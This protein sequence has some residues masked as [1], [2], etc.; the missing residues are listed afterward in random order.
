MKIPR[1][2]GTLRMQLIPRDGGVE[3]C[4]EAWWNIRAKQATQNIKRFAHAKQ[5]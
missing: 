3:V 2:C 4:V 5:E 1:S